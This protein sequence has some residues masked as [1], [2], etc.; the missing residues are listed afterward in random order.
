MENVVVLVEV[1]GVVGV[2]VVVQS[3]VVFRLEA[4]QQLS[5][6]TTTPTTS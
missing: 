1:V 5:Q 6:Q 4:P 2:A 3:V